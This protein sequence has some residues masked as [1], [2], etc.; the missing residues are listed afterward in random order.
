MKL[1]KFFNL[2]LIAAIFL[3][4]CTSTVRYS[5]Q[6]S[7]KNSTISNKSKSPDNNI[8][9]NLTSRRQMIINTAKQYIGTAYC[10]GGEGDNCFDCS[11][12]VKRVFG[13]VGVD[14]PRVSRNMFKF[15]YVVSVS[16][17]LPGDLVF[18]KK[19]ATINHVGIYLGN[20]KMIHASSSKG[21]VIQSLDDNYFQRRYAGIKNVLK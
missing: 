13:K 3:A 4:G 11:G 12:F 9:Y 17:A 7:V 21:V 2:F 5:S 19:G 18:F 10:Y 6:K 8:D 20:D 14:L 1:R 15:G 16:E